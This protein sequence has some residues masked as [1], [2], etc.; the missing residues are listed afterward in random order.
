MIFDFY[1]LKIQVQDAYYDK[2]EN[3]C[4]FQE[5]KYIRNY[6]SS[7]TWNLLYSN[8]DYDIHK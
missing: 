2:N 3:T 7:S 4:M 5:E 8:K 6:I 1:I